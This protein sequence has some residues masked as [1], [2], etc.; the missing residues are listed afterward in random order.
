MYFLDM[1]LLGFLCLHIHLVWAWVAGKIVFL[2]GGK[3]RHGQTNGEE[4]YVCVCEETFLQEQLLLSKG[5]WGFLIGFLVG[6]S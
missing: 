5:P 6:R 3:G 2:R 1:A 4:S